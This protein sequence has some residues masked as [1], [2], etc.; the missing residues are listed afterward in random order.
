MKKMM[1]DYLAWYYLADAQIRNG[2][3]D[4]ALVSIHY[5][6]SFSVPYPFKAKLLDMQVQLKEIQRQNNPKK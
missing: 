2:K 4:Q 5:A 1:N 6:L 3:F